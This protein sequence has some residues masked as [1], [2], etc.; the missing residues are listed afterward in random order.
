M[1]DHAPAMLEH[2][3]RVISVT[4]DSVLVETVRRSACGQ[5]NVG[6]DCGTSVIAQL[7]RHKTNR[8][9]VP[10]RVYQQGLGRQGL[11][12]HAGDE[13]VL[14]IP[15]QLLLHTALWAYMVPM[16]SMILFALIIETAGYADIYVFLA[17]MVGLFS[18]LYL[19]GAMHSRRLSDEIVLMRRQS[20]SIVTVNIDSHM[21]KEQ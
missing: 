17:S 20:P 4:A 6:A 14:G 15:E 19:T 16:L 8:V 13:V 5:C 1:S 21:R 2:S 10:N 12:L 3:G 11:E 9:R 18:G 7:F